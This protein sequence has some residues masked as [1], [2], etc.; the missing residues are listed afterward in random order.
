MFTPDWLLNGSTAMVMVIVSTA[1]VYLAM[2]VFSK[3]AGP[4]S[5]SQ[6][7]SFDI[8]VTI[9]LGSIIATTIV[10]KKP[11]VIQGGLAIATLLALQAG[12]AVLRRRAKFF[13]DTVDHA[14]LLLMAGH[15]I[16]WKNMRRAQM[17]RNDLWAELRQANVVN[18]DHLRAVVIE[19]TGEVTVLHGDSEDTKLDPA[20]LSGVMDGEQVPE[21]AE[22]LRN[23]NKEPPY[24]TNL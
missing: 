6:M 16:I 3:L 20:M 1:L 17:T 8:A 11:P 18:L 5:F 23:E 21:V 13:E 19:T 4:R 15:Q 2:I 10:A 12:V 14:P 7:S 9:A 22:A 24:R